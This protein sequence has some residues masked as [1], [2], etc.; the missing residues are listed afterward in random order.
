MIEIEVSEKFFG[1]FAALLNAVEDGNPNAIED[2]ARHG[3]KILEME[4]SAL[5]KAR[6]EQ[7]IDDLLAGV[8]VRAECLRLF[9]SGAI[10]PETAGD[11]YYE[12][13]AVLITALRNCADGVGF[14]DGPKD[15]RHLENLR[16]F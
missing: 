6:F 2:C 1:A 13:R 5:P 11:D 16:N 4:A 9:N 15:R 12:P 14:L 10:N 8:N 3:R 7:K